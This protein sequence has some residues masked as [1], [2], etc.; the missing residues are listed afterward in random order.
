MPCRIYSGRYLLRMLL[1][2]LSLCALAAL[3]LFDPFAGDQALFLIGSRML[4]NGAILYRD[5]WDIKQPGI[6]WFYEIGGKLFGFSQEGVRLCELIW[7]LG[8]GVVLIVTLQ[9][10]LDNRWTAIVA[11]VAY[12][13]TYF[14]CA[15]FWEMTQVEVIAPFPIYAAAFFLAREY[16]DR[17][18]QT[19][20]FAVAGLLAASAVVFKLVFA[21]IFIPLLGLRSRAG[22]RERAGRQ[23]FRSTPCGWACRLRSA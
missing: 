4:D 9:R 12:L 21:L 18:T 11:P 1:V 3:R 23:R 14:G 10:V 2:F 20:G 22:G 5:F 6:F 8:F 15:S 19:I 13:G 16:E 7:L 17:K